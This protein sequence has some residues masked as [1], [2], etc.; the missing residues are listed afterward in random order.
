MTNWELGNRKHPKNEKMERS[1]MY[2]RL[3]II[4]LGSEICFPGQ[5]A[6]VKKITRKYNKYVDTFTDGSKTG[7]NYI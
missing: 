5:S 6:K 4:Q 3:S 1:R 2:G 7:D